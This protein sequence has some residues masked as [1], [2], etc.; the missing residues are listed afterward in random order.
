MTRTRRDIYLLGNDS[1]KNHTLQ[2]HFGS[3][4]YVCG[5]D[6]NGAVHA[7]FFIGR[8]RNFVLESE[9]VT[10]LPVRFLLFF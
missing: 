10:R 8:R 7:K 2:N 5:D 6:R 1:C 4:E 3:N 9:H